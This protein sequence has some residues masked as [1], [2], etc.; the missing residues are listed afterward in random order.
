MVETPE[1]YI[2]SLAK[3]GKGL[4]KEGKGLAKEGKG[5]DKEGKGLVMLYYLNAH[6][7]ENITL[8]LKMSVTLD[9]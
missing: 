7:H 9:Q 3:E 8:T 5:L 2:S 6:M 4:A 1:P